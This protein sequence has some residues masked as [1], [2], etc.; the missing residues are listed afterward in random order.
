[1]CGDAE[2]IGLFGFG[3]SAHL[4]C[5]V[6]A[7]QGRRVFAVTRPGGSETSGRSRASSAPSGPGVIEELPE[8]LDAAIIFAPA[9]EL[10]PVGAAGPGA[11]RRRSFAPGST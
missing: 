4:V 11:R 7:H 1:M 2:R 9:G 6:A 8:E 10:V 3:A 5:Q